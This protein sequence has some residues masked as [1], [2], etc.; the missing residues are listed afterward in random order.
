[1]VSGEAT[2]KKAKVEPKED[3]K[4]EEPEQV[5]VLA[6]AQLSIGTTMSLPN[7]M[8][9]MFCDA[10]K[11]FIA[12]QTEVELNICANEFLC[13][14]YKGSWAKC[15]SEGELD[16]AKDMIYALA[17]AASEIT[18]VASREV[19]TV[20]A[21]L[22]N[23][24]AKFPTAHVQYYTMVDNPL[25]SNVAHFNLQPKHK[26]FWQAQALSCK[27]EGD[28]SLTTSLNSCGGLV[29]VNKWSGESKYTKVV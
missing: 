12:N 4:Q 24:L 2:P 10:N 16:P 1:M 26:V 21:E 20:G 18:M 8:T 17:D 19:T 7:K 29:P 27:K 5:Q 14:F 13:G 6:N 25:P 3:V 9:L 28:G 15:E 11:V 23:R 22:E